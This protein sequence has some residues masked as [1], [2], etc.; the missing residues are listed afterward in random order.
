MENDAF[1]VINVEI[2]NPNFSTEPNIPFMAQ[3]I[4]VV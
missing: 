1:E 3:V 4:T 2:Y